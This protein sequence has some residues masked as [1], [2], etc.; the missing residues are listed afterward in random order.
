M[1]YHET[2]SANVKPKVD[3]LSQVLGCM[4]FPSDKLLRNKLIE[5]LGL[6]FDVSNGPNVSS[7]LEG[8]GEYDPRSFHLL[9]VS[10]SNINL[11]FSYLFDSRLPNLTPFSVLT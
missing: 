4:K 1:V 5:S 8:F 10:D 7:L 2:I 6:Q 9:E 3:A 11:F